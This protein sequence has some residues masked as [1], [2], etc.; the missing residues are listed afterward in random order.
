MAST[1]FI[2][3][4]AETTCKSWYPPDHLQRSRTQVLF[5]FTY[6]VGITYLFIACHLF[7]YMQNELVLFETKDKSV[8]IPVNVDDET[9]WLSQSEMAYLFSTTKQNISLHINNCFREG[10][11]NKEV[12]VKE[13]LTTTPHGVIAG[14]TQTH[15][16]QYYN[17][18][19]IIS[20]GYRVKSQR[21]VEFRQWANRVLKQGLELLREE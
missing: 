17:L 9:V 14:K 5:F 19:V 1:I 15:N 4:Y 6:L 7:R 20:V 3:I 11:L 2:N 18:D 21:G 13:F 16:T 12:V 10:E 8:S